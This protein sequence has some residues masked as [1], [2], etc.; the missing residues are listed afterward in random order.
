MMEFVK[1]GLLI[2]QSR[3]WFW[4][5]SH[6]ETAGGGVVMVK[7]GTLKRVGVKFKLGISIDDSPTDSMS[8]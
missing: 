7:N 8:G 5:H 3:I 2:F 1:A 6:A 4:I